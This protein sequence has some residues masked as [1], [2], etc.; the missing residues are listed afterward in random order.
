MVQIR[1]KYAKTNAGRF[2]SHLDLMRAWERSI[3]RSGLPLAFSQGFNPHPKI[4]FGSALS[5]GV[6]SNGEYM[7]MELTEAVELTQLKERLTQNL[8]PALMLLD[9][10]EITQKTEALMAVID[11]ARYQLSAQLTETISETHLAQLLS[12]FWT[13][14]VINVLRFKKNSRNKR[15]VNIRPSIFALTAKMDGDCLQLE[16][17]VQTGSTGNVRPDEVVLGLMSVGLP[18]VN[19][20]MTIHREGLYVAKDNDLVSPFVFC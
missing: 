5:V 6:T 15:E 13:Q 3:R 7:D 11:R 8:P 14:D 1:I 10:Q 4:S 18:I 20:I 19:E 9:A 17:L 2:L 16:M 12:D